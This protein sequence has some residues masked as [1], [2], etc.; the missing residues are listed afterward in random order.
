MDAMPRRLLI[1][2]LSMLALLACRTVAPARELVGKWSTGTT[3]PDGV[4]GTSATYDFKS[5]G[6]FSMSGYPP[7]DVKGRWKVGKREAGK[8]E[9]TLFEQ[10]MTAPGMGASDWSDQTGWA[11]LGADGRTFTWNGQTFTKN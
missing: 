1:L 8:I 2:S 3:S 6:S 7:I 5:D 11:E 4:H 9:L 10:K